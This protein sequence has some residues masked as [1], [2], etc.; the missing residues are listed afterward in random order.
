LTKPDLR[1]TF[2][3]TGT[4]D[5]NKSFMNAALQSTV[6]HNSQPVTD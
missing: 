3:V 4:S 6:T 1:K 5:G 2:N